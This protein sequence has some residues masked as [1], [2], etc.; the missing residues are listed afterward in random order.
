MVAALART[1]EKS[2][3]QSPLTASRK[4]SPFWTSRICDGLEVGHGKRA[5]GCR[6]EPM[7]S[8]MTWVTTSASNEVRRMKRA[9]SPSAK[10]RRRGRLPVIHPSRASAPASAGRSPENP[11]LYGRDNRTPRG[12]PAWRTRH[13]CQN[14]PENAHLLRLIRPQPNQAL[15]RGLYPAESHLRQVYPRKSH[16]FSHLVRIGM[17][18]QKK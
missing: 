6:V 18:L 9:P 15:A 7:R 10:A 8:A 5:R 2:C 4:D 14:G 3:P 17:R 1:G 16:K 12:L 13:Q 11:H